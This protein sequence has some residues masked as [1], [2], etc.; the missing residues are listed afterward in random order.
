MSGGHFDY[1][2]HE[3]D[4]LTGDI[5]RLLE[6]NNSTEPDEYFAQMFN[7]ATVQ[8]FKNAIV[9]LRRA[10]AYL[11]RIDWLVSG[12]DAEATFHARLKADLDAIETPVSNI[13]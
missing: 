7:A 13:G 3:I 9:A 5:E 10:A 1:K 11:Q 12:D 8:E 2:Q 6:R 4:D